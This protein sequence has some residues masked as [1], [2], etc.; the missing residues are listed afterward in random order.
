MKKMNL[1][2]LSVVTAALVMTGCS[3]DSDDTT[4]SSGYTPPAA[5]TAPLEMN[6]SN[7]QNSVALL[8]SIMNS[9]SVNPKIAAKQ[10]AL[11][12]KVAAVKTL[13]AA[14]NVATAYDCSISGTWTIT[15]EYVSVPDDGFGGW[16]DTWSLAVNYDNCVDN[17]SILVDGVELNTVTSTGN[18]SYNQ[19]YGYNGETNLTY[20]NNSYVDNFK[21]VYE[22]NLTAGDMTSRT[23]NYNSSGSWNTSADG[24]LTIVEA[25]AY[26]E[27]DTYKG[28][29]SMTDT[30]SSGHAIN[31]WRNVGDEAYSS[32]ASQDGSHGEMNGDGFYAEYESNAT[33][34][35]LVYSTYLDNFAMTFANE[36]NETNSTVDGTVG[37]ICLGGSTTFDTVVTVQS[38]ESEYWSD[39][40]MTG[41]EVLPHDG[42]VT[43]TGSTSATLGFTTYDNSLPTPRTKAMVQAPDGNHTYFNW[44]DLIGS[45]PCASIMP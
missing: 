15:D 12:A 43:L 10:A 35:T 20:Q 39:Q 2:G 4:T 31:G 1:L 26:Y 45:S 18:W 13:A 44:T 40:N 29:E 36:N 14:P 6:L 19:A 28:T 42:N 33:D 9:M 16:S 32:A 11:T 24:M 34:E 21:Q 25:P 37:H 23:Y 22:T 3:S 8:N 27:S 17:T 30:N 5:V 38:N 41:P 7:V